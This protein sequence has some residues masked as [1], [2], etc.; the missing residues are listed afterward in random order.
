LLA[1]A[2]AAVLVLMDALRYSME[3]M[4]VLVVELLVLME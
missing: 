4:A 2:V 1:A 3:V